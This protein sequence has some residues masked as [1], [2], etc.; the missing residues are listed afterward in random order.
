MYPLF[1]SIVLIFLFKSS[2]IS[3]SLIFDLEVPIYATEQNEV[4]YN[5]YNDYPSAVMSQLFQKDFETWK[6]DQEK[7]KDEDSLPTPEMIESYGYAAEIHKVTTE[8]GYINSLHRIPPKSNCKL[9]SLFNVKCRLYFDITNK[10][11]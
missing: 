11:N 10:L 6:T 3:S 2:A 4:D 5:E 8:D 1:H 9:F 7:P